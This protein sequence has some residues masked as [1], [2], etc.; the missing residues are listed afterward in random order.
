LALQ[1]D[2]LGCH[3]P[4]FQ[5]CSTQ[6]TAAGILREEGFDIVLIGEAAEGDTDP[7]VFLEAL[8]EGGFDDPALVISSSVNDSWLLRCGEI[9]VDVFSS[10]NGWE[11]RALGNWICRAIART[12]LQR[13]HQRLQLV[14]RRRSADNRDGAGAQLDQLQLLAHQAME[15]H[16]PVTSHQAIVR[17]YLE[18]LQTFVLL[19]NDRLEHAFDQLARAV[20]QANLTA[21]QLLQVHCECQLALSKGC[22]NRSLGHLQQRADLFVIEMLVRLGDGYRR[23]S[24]LQGL[25]DHGIDLLQTQAPNP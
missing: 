18:L 12:E 9:E 11:S 6:A 8:R 20:Q 22:G 5:W 3:G 25:G 21:G 17:T 19:G 24:H 1:L 14:D 10:R 23:R 16:P 13:E 7:M 15:R 4:R 2:R